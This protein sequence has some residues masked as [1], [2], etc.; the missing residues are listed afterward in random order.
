M[1]PQIT[2]QDVNNLLIAG[3]PVLLLDVREPKEYAICQL[4][5]SVL[6]PLGDLP[7]RTHELDIPDG[8]KVVVYCHHGVRSLRG[9]GYLMQ[10]GFENVASMTG[11]IDWWSQLVDASVPRY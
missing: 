9:A 10:M 5:G 4:P 2:P 1:I 7:G 11:G 8:A 6:I 3:K